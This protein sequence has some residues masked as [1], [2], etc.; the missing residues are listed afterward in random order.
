[1]FKHEKVPGV[2]AY[3]GPAGGWGALQA[4]ALFLARRTSFH[5]GFDS[6]PFRRGHLVVKV[7]HPFLLTGVLLILHN[8]NASLFDWDDPGGGVNGPG[9]REIFLLCGEPVIVFFN[10]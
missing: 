2:G 1:M 9:F 8:T 6:A 7:F 5:V 3:G 10:D 4:V